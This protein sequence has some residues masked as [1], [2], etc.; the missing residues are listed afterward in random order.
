MPNLI[1]VDF[2]CHTIFSRDS[3]TSLESLPFTCQRKGL[4]RIAI[5]DHNT[6]AGARLAQQMFPELVIMGEEVMTTQGELLALYVQEELP[7]GLEP[8]AAMDRLRQQG[9][10]ISVSHPFDAARNGAWKPAHLARIAPLVDAIEIFNSRCLEMTA[11]RQAQLFARQHEL[12]GT[13][14]SDA[15][16]PQE[17]G[18]AALVLPAFETAE[19][20]RLSLKEARLEG[21]LSGIWVHFQSSYARWRKRAVRR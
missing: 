6:T 19:E 13:A 2:H 20:L 4:Q 8:E 10:F 9:A 3:L 16:T 11:N 18:R 5:T 1:R 21:R 14:G 15:H 12:A 7:R 17:F